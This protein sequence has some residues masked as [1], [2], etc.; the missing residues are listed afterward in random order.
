MSCSYCLCVLLAHSEYKAIKLAW[1]FYA[2]QS[3]KR[4]GLALEFKICF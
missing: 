2:E 3:T 1:N 4:C